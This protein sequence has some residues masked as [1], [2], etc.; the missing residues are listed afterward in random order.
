MSM[1]SPP[2]QR[3]LENVCSIWVVMRW[4]ISYITYICYVAGLMCLNG[5]WAAKFQRFWWLFSPKS[6]QTNVMRSQV[7][8]VRNVLVVCLSHL[9]SLFWRSTRMISKMEA[10][11]VTDIT[12]VFWSYKTNIKISWDLCAVYSFMLFFTYCDNIKVTTMILHV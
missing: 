5:A 10:C 3:L 8:C 12:T 6:C 11:D 4:E 2:T 9:L 7:L 1:G